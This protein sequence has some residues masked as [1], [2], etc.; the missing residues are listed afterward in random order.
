MLKEFIECGNALV[1]V[2]GGEIDQHSAESI[3]QRIDVEFELNSKRNLV[4]DLSDVSFMDSA[5]IGLII[6][7][8]KLVSAVGGKV[9]LAG[10][11]N[12]LKKILDLSGVR[13]L[14]KSYPDYRTAVEDMLR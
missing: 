9:A 6:G 12:K 2:L 4:I 5:G 8:S 1:A 10:A 11:G 3:R 13:M 7:R 14:V